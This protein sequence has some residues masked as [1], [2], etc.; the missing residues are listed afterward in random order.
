MGTQHALGAGAALVQ[1]PDAVPVGSSTAR[2][3]PACARRVPDRGAA[4]RFQDFTRDPI[5]H[6]PMPPSRPSPSATARPPRRSCRTIERQGLTLLGIAL[7]N[8]EDAPLS[9]SCSPSSAGTRSTHSD[10]VLRPIRHDGHHAGGVAR[11]RAEPVSRCR[12]IEV[13]AIH[14]SG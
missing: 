11:S 1:E 7:T 12:L 9:S 8:L 3:A 13:L 6:A 14:L 5:A 4:L 10:S 2:P